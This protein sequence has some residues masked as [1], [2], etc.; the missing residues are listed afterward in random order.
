MGLVTLLVAMFFL[1]ETM[2]LSGMGHREDRT[3]RI[4]DYYKEGRQ[5]EE[6]RGTPIDGGGGSSNLLWFQLGP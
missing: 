5:V 2:D 4:L 1:S 6:G 3:K